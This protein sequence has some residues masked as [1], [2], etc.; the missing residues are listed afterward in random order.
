MPAYVLIGY[1]NVTRGPGFLGAKHSY[2]YLTDTESGPAGL[3]LPPEITAGRQARR[4]ALL[5]KVR[6]GYLAR[7]ADRSS[8]NTTRRSP[9]PCAWPG[10]SSAESSS[11]TKSPAAL[12]EAYGGEFGQRCLLA[13]RLVEAGVRFIE[14]SHNLNFLNGTGWDVHND[15]IQ[16]QHALIQ[17]LD[18]ALATLVLDLESKKLL[19]KTL[20]VVATEFGRPASSTAAAAAATTARASRS[21]WPAAASKRARPSA[22]PTTWPCPSSAGPSASPTC[23]PPCSP[24]SAS[25]P[26]PNSSPASAPCRSRMAV[27][28][29]RSCSS[30]R[31]SQGGDKSVSMRFRLR[32]RFLPSLP[33]LTSVQSPSPTD[34]EQKETKVTKFSL[35][36]STLPAG[37]ISTYDNCPTHT[38]R[39][40]PSR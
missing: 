37:S 11:S 5:A 27:C 36:H 38:N 30:Q 6:A 35:N 14:V 12:R 8:S 22:R 31:K 15:G 18:Q 26:A 4:E 24:A 33:S 25:A 32:S 39:V 9:R 19:D 20:I 7:Q 29:F 17:E 1:P 16:K 21:P 13:R 34:F 3:S 23:T 2:V 40:A 28:R 10:R